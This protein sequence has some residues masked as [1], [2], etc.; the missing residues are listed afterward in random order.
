MGKKTELVKRIAVQGCAG[1]S[2]RDCPFSTTGYPCSVYLQKGVFDSPEIKAQARAWL[3]ARAKRKA[4]K[5]ARKAEQ[6]AASEISV[7]VK[8]YGLGITDEPV[9]E[10]TVD[11]E[12]YK[13]GDRFRWVG[14]NNE[15]HKYGD[16][17]TI[18]GF[19]NGGAVFYQCGWEWQVWIKE[20]WHRINDAPAKPAWDGEFVPGKFYV[21]EDG[22]IVRC[23]MG[24]AK[25]DDM[26]CGASINGALDKMAWLDTWNKSA[27]RPVK[28]KITV[29]D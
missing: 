19:V 13:V 9:T 11:G 16:I 15:A 10:I 1:E 3:E 12:V 8:K 14:S 21:A 17:R 27:F 29:E 22:E 4:E 2:C 7:D 5:K 20:L 25:T 6:M 26:F 18:K 23:I 24:K 28:V